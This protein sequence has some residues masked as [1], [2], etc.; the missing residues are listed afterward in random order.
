MVVIELV[1]RLRFQ[2]LKYYIE[3][4]LVF[5]KGMTEGVEWACECRH[6]PCHPKIKFIISNNSNKALRHAAGGAVG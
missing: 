3:G 4:A 2:W 5:F 6:T 1:S